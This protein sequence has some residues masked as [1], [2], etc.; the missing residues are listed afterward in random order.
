MV[1]IFV[2]PGLL[3]SFAAGVALLGVLSAARVRSGMVGGTASA[4]LGIAAA[5]GVAAL[6]TTR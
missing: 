4:V 2:I 5:A 3:A 6:W 1:V